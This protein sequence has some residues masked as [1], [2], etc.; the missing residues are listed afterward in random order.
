MVWSTDIVPL[1]SLGDGVL[2]DAG[3]ARLAEAPDAGE[4]DTLSTI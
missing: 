4:D 1:A 2:S 3:C